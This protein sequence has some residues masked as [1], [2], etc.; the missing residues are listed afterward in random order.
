MKNLAKKIATGF[1]AVTVIT[2]GLTANIST[3]E[4]FGL[5]DITGAIFGGGGNSGGGSV[6]VDG[7]TKQHDNLI[8][9]LAISTALMNAAF[10]NCQYATGETIENRHLI[11]TETVTKSVVKTDL[12]EATK[13]KDAANKAKKDKTADTI[14]K[15]LDAALSS[16]D[17]AKLKEIDDYIKA[18]NEQRLL[19]D[20]L[21]AVALVQA[22]IIIKETAQGGLSLANVTNIVKFANTAKQVESLLKTRNQF[23]K[24]LSE[25]TAVYKQNRGIKDPT[26]AEIDKTAKTMEA[27]D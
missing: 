4:A 25:A 11:I 20:A 6:N 9:N 7:L 5:G 10:Q 24:M 17:E 12:A 16:G 22:G 14:K 23:S 2:T 13:M 1:L 18:A 15:N 26:K 21:G 19:S 3:V 8:S 27:N